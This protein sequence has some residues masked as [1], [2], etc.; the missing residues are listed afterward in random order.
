MK[1][2]QREVMEYDVL[3]VGAGPSGLSCAIHLKQLNESLNV[4]L[5]DKAAQIG[6]HILSGAVLEPDSLYQLLP[7]IQ[8]L[9]HP[10]KTPVTK[11]KFL[12]L[13]SKHALRLPTPKP[14]RNH[15]NYIISLGELCRFLA[16]QAES[17]GIEIYP[18]FAAVET[19]IEN[20]RIKGVI[21]GD[22]GLDRDGQPLPNHQAGIELRAKHTVFAEGCRGNL[23]EQLIKTF[24]LRQSPQT[25]A[26]GIKEIWQV[27]NPLVQEGLVIH[28]VGWPLNHKTYG[29]S[30]MYHMAE[31]KI[32]YGFVTG[33]DYQNPYLDPFQES[34][35]FK[36]HPAIKPY[37][38]GGERIAYGA[39]ALNE[40]GFQ[41]I[42]TL[43]PPGG[44]LI[45]CS[46]GFLNVPKIK[47]NHNAILSGMIAAKAIVE[48]TTEKYHQQILDS[49]IGK[50]L[51]QVRNIRPGFKWGLIPGLIHAAIDTYI[52]RG[53]APWTL[54]HH[55]DNLALKPA[56][57]S[58]KID[59]PK[60][61]NKLTFDKLTSVYLCNIA[62]EENQPCHLKLRQN[63]IPIDVNYELYAS[64]ETR[65]C[66]A[67]VY[68]IIDVD[69]K[70]QLKINAQNCI[71]CKTC[72]IKDPKQNIHWCPPQGG[73]G[74]NY[75]EM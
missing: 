44:L 25:Y 75:T 20:Q 50:E 17:L 53:K 28:S 21:T 14:M 36:T 9:D 47:G 6:S 49:A 2:M 13:T 69:D 65:Y 40:G 29:G 19:I 64:P 67:Y 5:I 48:E 18:G 24:K 16:K 1:S 70:P 10:L 52:L 32:A 60:P 59:Y 30:F 55:A 15:G 12:F 37:F 51:Y 71:H 56:K 33:L 11:D 23:T 58:L 61:D 38:E 35:R 72:D 43:N 41:S 3:I 4:C 46:A 73:S 39:R 27:D 74:P 54:T 66:P 42:P 62:H 8:E 34:Q 22:M 45:G 26:L 68:E 57:S 7:N 63:E 31:N